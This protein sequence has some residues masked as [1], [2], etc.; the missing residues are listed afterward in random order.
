M[1]PFILRTVFV[2]LLTL[3]SHIKLTTQSKPNFC[4]QLNKVSF[5]E[6]NSE[7]G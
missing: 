6:N 1:A 7:I 2:G 4:E 3:R 5:F